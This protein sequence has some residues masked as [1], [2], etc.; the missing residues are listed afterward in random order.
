MDQASRYFREAVTGILS[1]KYYDQHAADI[2]ACVYVQRNRIER[3]AVHEQPVFGNE[4]K[5]WGLL[6][7]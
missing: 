5:A 3:P 6:R 1:T 7:S 4:R 2:P